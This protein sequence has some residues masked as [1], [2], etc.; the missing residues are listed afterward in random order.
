MLAAAT[1]AVGCV[2]FQFDAAVSRAATTARLPG[3]LRRLINFPE[4][5][6]HGLGVA[7]LIVG[8]A[9][10]DPMLWRKPQG[11]WW[12]PSPDLLRFVGATYAGSLLVDAIKMS[13]VRVRPQAINLAAIDSAFPAFGQA[14]AAAAGAT[15]NDLMSFPSGHSAIAAGFAAAASCRYPHATVFFAVVALAAMAQRLFSAA[16]FPSDVCFGA[17][18]GLLGAAAC[19]G[20]TRRE[21]A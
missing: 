5:A 13:T 6:A 15:G 8:I 3:D 17:C 2:A 21:T 19:L 14:A 18:L 12:K 1:A 9:V 10:L 11:A 16:H 4:V 20:G 7:C